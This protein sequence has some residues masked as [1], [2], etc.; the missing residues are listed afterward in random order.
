MIWYL[1]KDY[2][3]DHEAKRLVEEAKLADVPFKVVAPKDFDLVVT[4][5]D[6]R[7]I[8]FKAGTVSLP[9]VVVPRTGSG[10]DSYRRIHGQDVFNSNSEATQHSSPANY[11]GSL[12][13][14]R[15]LCWKR[16][17]LSLRY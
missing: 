5:D 3:F 17:W 1:R 8:R 10:T 12:S 7:S 4:R 13:R 15:Y 14:R 9:D 11:V 16:N 2:K 6:R